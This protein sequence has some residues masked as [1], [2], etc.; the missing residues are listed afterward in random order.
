MRKL[1]ALALLLTVSVSARW[2]GLGTDSTNWAADKIV[3]MTGTSPANTSVTALTAY[4]RTLLDD[5]NAA[6]AQTTLGVLIG[7]NTQAWDT[8]LDDIAALVPTDSYIIVGDGANWVR[9]TGATARTSL[10]AQAQSTVLDDIAALGVTNGNLLLSDGA[11]WQVLGIGTNTYVLQS[12]GS[13]A[14]WVDAATLPAASISQL[15]ASDGTP[16]GVVAVDAVGA[17]SVNGQMTFD[18]DLTYGATTGLFFGDG[19]TGLFESNDNQLDLYV[20]G[21]SRARLLA[22]SLASLTSGSWRVVHTASDA[23]TPVYTF[24][25]DANTGIGKG[26]ADAV[27]LIVGGQTG[28]RVREVSSLITVTGGTGPLVEVQTDFSSGVDYDDFVI[29]RDIDNNGGGTPTEAG[30][31]LH[32]VRDVT[33]FNTVSGNFIE[34]SNDGATP[35]VSIDAI[36]QLRLDRGLTYGTTTGVFFG[37]GNTG[38]YEAGDNNPKVYVNGSDRWEFLANKFQANNNSGPILSNLSAT[39]TVPT[40]G[41]NRADTD[42]G[43]GQNA[44]DQVSHIAGGVELIR[45]IEDTTDS[46]RIGSPATTYVEVDSA[47]DVCYVGSGSGIPYAEISVNG[48]TTGLT[49]TDQNTWYQFV[50]FDTDGVSNNATPDHTEDHIIVDKAGDYR[51]TLSCSFSGSASADTYEVQMK[52]ENGTV[53]FANAHLERKM[54]ATG[55]IGSASFNA[56]ITA[57]A[58]DTLEIWVRCTNAAGKVFTGRDVT[59]TMAQIGGD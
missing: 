22:S 8:H 12:D 34:L 2:A 41:P 36:G 25:G 31:L 4:M 45:L 5:A 51:V 48:N 17:I 7:T 38:F 39:A 23:T 59:F 55:D 30:A 26:T 24:V 11:N 27:D 16:A 15:D 46:V 47:G 18:T 3:Y 32:L 37:D 13:T 52:T 21:A 10:G 50:G 44:V 40:V 19:N 1:L 33:N 14:S 35:L 42:S 6:A 20:A 58:T 49:C 28:L 29:K 54:S 43:M 53:D 56:F 57:A 9:E